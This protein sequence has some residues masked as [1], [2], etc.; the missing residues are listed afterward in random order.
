MCVWV[1]WGG[2]I[3]SI[4]KQQTHVRACASWR[5]SMYGGACYDNQHLN[6]RERNLIYP[7]IVNMSTSCI[8]CRSRP[9]LVCVRCAY[10][11]IILDA[12]SRL[13]MMARSCTRTT[14]YPNVSV[15]VS[16]FGNIT[17]I[18]TYRTTRAR[19]A[20]IPAEPRRAIAPVPPATPLG[21]TTLPHTSTCHYGHHPIR[22]K[23]PRLTS[24][25]ARARRDCGRA[26]GRGV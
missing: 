11:H 22:P 7:T 6:Q 1:G 21:T 2:Y 26:S 23:H 15:I 19:R 3:T 14:S 24:T 10:N 18:V 4:G 25:I 20:Y 12:R 17:T 9:L 16:K 8:M 13:A 5:D